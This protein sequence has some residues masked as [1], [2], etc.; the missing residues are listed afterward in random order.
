M[1]KQRTGDEFLAWLHRHRR[2]MWEDAQRRGLS[3]ADF[4]REINERAMA[5]WQEMQKRESPAD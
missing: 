2:E 1:T 4:I 5:A 3:S